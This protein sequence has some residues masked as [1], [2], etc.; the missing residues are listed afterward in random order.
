MDPEEVLERQRRRVKRRYYRT[1]DSISKARA[2][3]QSLTQQH[4][5]LLAQH[6]REQ[7]GEES[8]PH[9]LALHKY[10]QASAL[11]ERLRSEK[12]QLTELLEQRERLQIRLTTLLGECREDVSVPQWLRSVH[13]SIH[14]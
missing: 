12:Q 1:I 9:Q 8:D 3:V 7:S 5:T 10:A 13:A 2:L 11:T 6:A 4:Q 14:V